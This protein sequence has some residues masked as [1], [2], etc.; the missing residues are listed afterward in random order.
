MDFVIRRALDHARGV[1]VDMATGIDWCSATLNNTMADVTDA[2]FETEVVERSK[3][4]PV[5]VD[6]WAEWCGP[7]KQLGPILEKLVAATNGQVELA[8]VDVDANPAVGQAF[9]VQSIP[10]VYAMKDGQVVDSFTGA[11]GEAQVQ[12]FVDKLLPGNEISEIDR[13]VA[14]GDEASLIKALEIQTDYP[15]AVTG[16]AALLVEQGETETGLQLLERIPESPETRRI[17]ALAR[18]GGVG[19]DVESTLAEL[20]SS[21]KTDEEARQKFVDLLEVLGPQDPRTAGWRRKLSA[22]LF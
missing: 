8:K 1:V 12:E 13:L 10:A 14:A 17:T 22:S 6:L 20:L 3:T 15:A 5:I 4:V 19:D 7:C 11:Q 18:T 9:K 21:V 16:L 2:T